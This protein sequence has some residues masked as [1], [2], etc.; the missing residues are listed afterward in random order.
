MPD[1]NKKIAVLMGGLSAEREISF[2]TGRAVEQALRNLGY[3]TV[4]IDAGRDLVD[5]LREAGP[6]A[7]FIALHGKYGED[8]IVQGVLELMGLPYTG[9]GVLASAVAMDKAAAKKI[10]S[11]AG[12]PTPDFVEFT[13]ETWDSRSM[14]ELP[15][16]FPAVVKPP[17]EGSAIGITI[18]DSIDAL[19]KALETGFKEY[20]RLMVE[21]F[22][23]G[24]ELTVGI[25]DDTAL[26][27]VE[28]IPDGEFYDFDAKYTAGMSRHLVPA[29]VPESTAV[30]A[31]QTALSVHR[32]IGCKGATRIDIRLDHVTSQPWVLEINTIPGMTE[33]SLLPEAA[34]SAGIGFDDLVERILL[35]AFS[36]ERV[37]A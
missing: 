25:L 31:Q 24:R 18:V 36:G 32:A 2:K 23:D 19:R 21:A 28:I 33:T 1:K 6:D 5:R 11:A 35:T 10:M 20:D 14:P 30:M 34:A 9:S 13:R 7:V 3:E 17:C 15:F 12:I 16:S 27:V 37:H 22:V 29:P 8:G 26:P 4:A